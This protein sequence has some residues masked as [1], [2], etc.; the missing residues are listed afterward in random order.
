M[1][2]DTLTAGPDLDTIDFDKL[3]KGNMLD[4]PPAPPE[5]P[6][7]I[8]AETPEEV[9]EESTQETPEE[10]KED[11]PRDAKGKFAK[12]EREVPD[13][14]PKERF[15]EAV[16]KEREAREQAERRAQELEQQ[17][18][19]REQQEQAAA[20]RSEQVAALDKQIDDLEAQRDAML[21]DG[22]KDKAT[23]LAK[24]IRDLNRQVARLESQEDSSAIVNETL[25]RERLGAAVARWEAE[26]PELNPR[27]ESYDK[28]LVEM[29]LPIQHARVA[30]GVPP[31]QALNEAVEK[32]MSRLTAREPSAS[33]EGLERAKAEAKEK[34][35]ERRKAQVEKAVEASNKQPPSLQ[36]IGLDSDK[37]GEPKLPDVSKMTMEEF[38]ALPE[39]TRARL[40][41]DLV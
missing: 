18:R 29:I 38:A 2:P 13:H 11:P 31:S 17:L 8:A 20:K 41:G 25:E 6:A 14:I 32:V 1:D 36:T 19:A 34:A 4:E 28:D 27:S 7:D 35:G 15:N 40:R 23:A 3:D 24:Q 21:L 10:Q 22:E 39:S 9:A 12:K 5:E 30:Q 33:K 37:A 26:Y 16:G